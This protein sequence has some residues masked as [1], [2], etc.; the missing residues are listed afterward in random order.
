MDGTFIGKE[1][2]VYM[3]GASK[4]IARNATFTGT[5]TNSAIKVTGT[6]DVD[7]TNSTMKS[8][9]TYAVMNEAGDGGHCVIR[10][11]ASNFGITG[12]IYGYVMATTCTSTGQTS[13]VVRVYNPQTAKVF[14][15]TWTDKN[16]QDDIKWY[17]S[18]KAS[19]TNYCDIRIYKSNHNNETGKYNVHVWDTTDGSTARATIGSIVIT[20]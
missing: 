18:T 20:F 15:P 6:S 16:G 10:S 17:S 4:V 1:N 19:G 2:G 7:I 13:E 11:R 14:F 3:E 8:S 9:G 12:G 5:G